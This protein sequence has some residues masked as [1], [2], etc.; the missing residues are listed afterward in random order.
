M[1]LRYAFTMRT[2]E[3]QVQYEDGGY[4]AA[5]HEDLNGLRFS[6]IA[7]GASWEALKSDVQDVVNAIYYDTPKPDRVTLHLVHDEELQIV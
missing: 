5:G 3:L 1:A 2:V 6:I 7:E 4:V